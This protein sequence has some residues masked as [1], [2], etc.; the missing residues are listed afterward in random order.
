MDFAMSIH[1]DVNVG[2]TP[3]APFGD[4]HSLSTPC[5]GGAERPAREIADIR[6]DILSQVVAETEPA[7]LT[8]HWRF[9]PT[10]PRV[11]QFGGDP[12]DLAASLQQ[13][14]GTDDL[15]ASRVLIRSR[16]SE[17]Q[18]SPVF[19][20][21]SSKF[22]LM[23]DEND[24]PINAISARG[25]L[26]SS[27]PPFLKYALARHSKGAPDLPTCMILASTDDDLQVFHQLGFNC[28]SA[29]GLERLCGKHA[30]Q[31]FGPS[32]LDDCHRK[33]VFTLTDWQ[34]A[35]VVNEP[36]RLTQQVYSQLCK[37]EQVFNFDPGRLFKVWCPAEEDLAVLQSALAFGDAKVIQTLLFNSHNGPRSTPRQCWNKIQELVDTDL[38]TA[39]AAL[40][41]AIG[42]S[43]DVPRPG[44]VRVAAERLRRSFDRS[45]IHKF[46]AQADA[47][48]DAGEKM[49]LLMNS[50]LA[51]Q[52]FDKQELL[53]TAQS[54]VAG[55]CPPYRG[56]IDDNYLDE[57]LRIVNAIIKIHR[58][59]LRHN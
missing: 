32:F 36:S 51:Q 9:L 4:D 52:W 17:L 21:A 1:S 33:Y 26:S 49:L 7:Q 27:A 55:E 38:A 47:T 42:R 44:E 25:K 6:V 12:R 23:C 46:N 56:V 14:F 28:T 30:R 57:R 34:I 41:H 24:R 3:R 31:L 16:D 18:L 8:N 45:V 37:M 35:D 59:Q 5:R 43:R 50:E 48:F 54:V 40:M 53:A 2:A 11:R 13:H 20:D 10:S 39:R 19:G 15:V 58:E 29:A 22:L